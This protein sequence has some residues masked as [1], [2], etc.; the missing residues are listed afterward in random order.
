MQDSA[1]VRK[2]NSILTGRFIKH[3]EGIAKRKPEDYESF[4]K[5]FGTYIKE[6][7]STDFEHRET[8]AK[9]LRY[10][11]SQTEPG[12][13]TSLQEYVDRAREEQKDIYFLYGA[14]RQSIESGPYLEAFKAR[15]IEVLYVTEP[16]DEFVLNHVHTFADKRILSADSKDI[17]LPPLDDPSKGR[18]LAKDKLDSL[19]AWMT[20]KLG[21]RVSEVTASE[22]LVESPA[23]VL[24]ADPMMT[25]QMRRIMQSLGDAPD[26]PAP[27]VAFQVNPRHKLVRNLYEL[28]QSDESSAGLVL[29]TV[30]DNAM[31]A[32]GLLD[33]PKDMVNRVYQI[34]EQV[35]KKNA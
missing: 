34:L 7:V 35:S 11:S 23:I 6:G 14:G 8:L 13:L 4:W 15:G 17:E 3:L 12:K 21:D 24:N 30:F 20:E 22:R 32:A 2:L 10:E 19:L 16:A 5:A 25:G 18:P 33:D 29:Q 9:L 27:A 26:S 28:S 31:M 1:L